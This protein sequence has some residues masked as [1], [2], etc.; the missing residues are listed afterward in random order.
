MVYQ[1]VN[2]ITEQWIECCGSME[3]NSGSKLKWLVWC[4]LSHMLIKA[5]IWC[6]GGVPGLK[7]DVVS[8][9]ETQS[10]TPASLLVS[11]VLGA[12]RLNSGWSLLPEP[13]SLLPIPLFA[14]LLAPF[15]YPPTHTLT[16]SHI[17]THIKTDLEHGLIQPLTV[18]NLQLLVTNWTMVVLFT[19]ILPLRMFSS[20]ALIYNLVSTVCQNGNYSSINLA[21][22]SSVGNM[23][24][25]Y[26]QKYRE[27]V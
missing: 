12:I 27:T 3:L 4:F 16:H 26:I 21:M 8:W 20:K 18:P 23:Y 15:T 22:R 25:L 19:S 2:R 7:P 1:R 17:R 9:R 6:L 24:A 13:T 10:T 5:D 14:L 11:S